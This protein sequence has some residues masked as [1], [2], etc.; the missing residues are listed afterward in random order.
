MQPTSQKR[1]THLRWNMLRAFCQPSNLA[2][3]TSFPDERRLPLGANSTRCIPYAAGCW[4]ILNLALRNPTKTTLTNCGHHQKNRT[5]HFPLNISSHNI[6]WPSQSRSTDSFLP[7]VY[8]IHSPLWASRQILTEGGGHTP[9]TP[10]T[11]FH[12]NVISSHC[13][14]LLTPPPR[15][16]PLPQCYANLCCA[17][18]RC[19]NNSLSGGGGGKLGALARK[20]RYHFH[21]GAWLPYSWRLLFGPPLQ[22]HVSNDSDFLGC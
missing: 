7:Q 1:L 8:R 9:P 11:I 18:N 21:G 13:W 17:L 15:D 5:K 12:R 3:V 4:D 22:T 14:P 10:R 2:S 6:Q 19:P 20:E 16:T